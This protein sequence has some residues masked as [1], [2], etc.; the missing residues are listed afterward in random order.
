[1]SSADHGGMSAA[2]RRPQCPRRGGQFRRTP[3]LWCV[4]TWKVW[5]CDEREAPRCCTR[6]R[7]R[8]SWNSWS[9]G[10]KAWCRIR[11]TRAAQWNMTSRKSRDH[12][13]QMGVF[14]DLSAALR[15]LTE[16]SSRVL[17]SAWQSKAARGSFAPCRPP[18]TLGSGQR[19]DPLQR[20]RPK[21]LQRLVELSLARCCGAAAGPEG[22]RMAQ[23]LSHNLRCCHH[24]GARYSSRAAARGASTRL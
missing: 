2:D 11:A 9:S 10:V 21:C 17:T 7:P 24:C 8:S 3:Q 16:H 23:A 1:M 19:Y 15:G 13:P 5:T 20:L 4:H 22:K 6:A 14:Q 12:L 18:S